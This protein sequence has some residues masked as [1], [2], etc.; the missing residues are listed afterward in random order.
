[1]HFP[2]PDAP[3]SRIEAFGNS[4]VVLIDRDQLDSSLL[5]KKPTARIPHTGG[6]RIK[7]GS[8]EEAVL[9][10]WIVK[11]SHLSG[12]ELAA[13]LKYGEMENAG[14]GASEPGAELRRLTHSQYDHTVR[15]LLGDQTSPAMQ[16]PPEDFI[17]GFRNQSR[18]Q[19]LSPLLVEGYSNAAEKLASSAF[20][21]GDTR[22]LIPCKP[23]VPCRARFVR[24]FGQKAFRRPLDAIE[25]RRYEALFTQGTDFMK[26]A[27]LVVEAMLQSP[28]F[29]FWLDTT[30]DPKLRP[31]ATAS[32]LSYSLWDTMP[33]AELFAAAQ[34]GELATPAGLEKE[35]RRMLADPR[36]HESLDE[37]VS[38]W[39]RF[40]R[41]LTASKDRR[42]FP[43]FTR[44][45]A[46]AMT[47]EARMFVSDLVW[48]D[49]D[50]MTL[51][52][53]DYGYVS[54]E[55]ARIYGVATP[56]KDFDRGS[57]P[58]DSERAGIL[59]EGLFLA[60]TAK[61]DDSSPTARGLFVREQFLCQ[62]V[63]DPPPGV[64][65]NLPPVT[66]AKPQTNRDRMSEH[67]TNSSC[68]GCHKLMDGV[69]FG[70]E[71][72]DAIGAKRE[73]LVL[74]FRTKHEDDDEEDEG[75]HAAKRT[76]TL[77][78]NTT[79]YV[80]GI[81]DSDFT[82]PRQLGALLAK[83]SQCQQCIVK[84]YFRFQAGRADT[85][86]DRPLIRLVSD[87]FRNSGFRFKELIMSL[88]VLREFPSAGA[89][90]N[91][92]SRGAIER[93]ADNNSPR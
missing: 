69:G 43:Y 65:T 73:Q 82:S 9:R 33:D 20:R 4:L 3:A 35:A 49:R 13:A 6:E 78:L 36:A 86:A 47:T 77:P 46:H 23:S 18:G 68:A 71:K 57:F 90:Q 32:R 85:P 83:S 39:L 30:T 89:Q 11:L 70:L 64:N 93:V 74:E 5:L 24:E 15:D 52:T 14:G 54:P 60:L 41:L 61:P 34:R 31:W 63:P 92:Q 37:F 72:F 81:P 62:H 88:V 21:G 19:S 91:T 7:P 38:Q 75:K 59:G 53:A 87:N 79:A 67:T 80:A 17:N 48:D 55:L 22:G 16:F 76:I 42:K 58:A 10:A 45:T 56:A 1:M 40:D 26:G 84:Q 25:Q 29:L 28:N 2:E 51:F 8:P 44:E 50:F 12:S 66:E 27:Q